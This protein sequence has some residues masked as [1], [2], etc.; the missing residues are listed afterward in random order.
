MVQVAG[1]PRDVMGVEVGPGLW[2]E[3]GGVVARC[4]ICGS[5]AVRA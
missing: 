3:S 4:R 1:G 2:Q 5:G